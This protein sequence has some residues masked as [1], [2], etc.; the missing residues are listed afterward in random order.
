MTDE[1]SFRGRFTTHGLRCERLETTPP[2]EGESEDD[3]SEVFYRDTCNDV[4][5]PHGPSCRRCRRISH[6]THTITRGIILACTESEKCRML[7]GSNVCLGGYEC[8]WVYS[9]SVFFFSCGPFTTNLRLL[10]VCLSV[11]ALVSSFFLRY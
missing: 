5:L 8:W 9:L 6:S 3:C 2:Q 7:F 4:V 11:Y 10:S 1:D